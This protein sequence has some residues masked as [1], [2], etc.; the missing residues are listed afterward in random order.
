MGEGTSVPGRMDLF[1]S[2]PW[3]CHPEVWIL[4]VPHLRQHLRVLD[5]LSVAAAGVGTDPVVDQQ[6]AVCS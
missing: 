1:T 5:C 3:R 6:V 2:I 4:V